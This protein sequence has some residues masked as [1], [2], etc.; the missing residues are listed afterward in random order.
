VGGRQGAGHV[1]GQEEEG[2]LQV[3]GNQDRVP[4]L[5]QEGLPVLLLLRGFPLRAFELDPGGHESAPRDG[6]EEVG[7][8]HLA[9]FHLDP[10]GCPD[11]TGIPVR[12]GQETE[13]S[14][15]LEFGPC[16]LWEAGDQLEADPL[17]QLALEE[18]LGALPGH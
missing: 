16:Q 18:V 9:A 4:L 11:G 13:G 17:N 14:G 7:H 6:Q 10:D 2:L 15:L 1:V 3:L 8:A 12:D 5:L